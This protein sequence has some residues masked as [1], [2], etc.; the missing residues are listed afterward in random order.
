MCAFCVCKRRETGQSDHVTYNMASGPQVM[1]ARVIVCVMAI[2]HLVSSKTLRG[3]VYV[4]MV[5][6]LSTGHASHGFSYAK[7]MPI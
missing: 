4:R 2:I 5:W 3:C 6:H 1:V 7:R